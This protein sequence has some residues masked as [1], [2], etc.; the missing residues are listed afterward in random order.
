MCLC[1]INTLQRGAMCELKKFLESIDN[2]NLY[3]HQKLIKY[4]VR[5][6]LS[7]DEDVV[8]KC[9]QKFNAEIADKDIHG[10]LDLIEPVMRAYREKEYE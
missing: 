3:K 2:Y 1:L 4:G 9:F 8:D 7:D 6:C 5:I 10:L